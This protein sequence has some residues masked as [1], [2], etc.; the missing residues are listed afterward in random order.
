MKNKLL[1]ITILLIALCCAHST[2]VQ[3]QEKEHIVFYP[4]W[5]PQSQFLGYYVAQEMGF[6]ADEG[7]EVEIRHIGVNENQTILSKL[8]SGEADIIGQQLLQSIMSRSEGHPI[9]NVMQTTQNCGLCC[10]ANKALSTPSD[11]NGLKISRWSMGYAETTEIIENDLQLDIDWVPSLG[12]T[13]LFIYNAVDATL[14]YTY[15]EYIK[16]MYAKGYIPEENVLRF[17]DFGFNYPE[18]GLY[19]T[20]DYYAEHKDAIE[21]FVRASKKGWQYVREH[22]DEAMKYTFIYTQANHIVT[23][24]AFEKSMCMEYLRL[25][26]NPTTGEADFAPVS[27]AVF[28]EMVEKLKANGVIEN[29]VNY[30]DFVR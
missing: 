17:G 3:A 30:K 18:D 29:T 20:E 23:N 26:I 6:Y 19:V 5:T 7:L 9:V 14:C 24:L 8:I 1:H 10:I 28:N 16:L 13:N 25:Q 27:E 22:T 15:S 12:S 11:L 2:R 21:K 4:Q